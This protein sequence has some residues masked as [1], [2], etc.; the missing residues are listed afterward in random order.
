MR[1]TVRILAV[2]GIVAALVGGADATALAS[3]TPVTAALTKNGS[4]VTA[5]YA[6]YLGRSPSQ[7]DIDY[8]SAKLAAG[9][10]RTVISDSFV[11]SDEYRMIRITEAY[12]H[13]LGRGVD[14]GGATTWLNYMK[15][16]V[17]TTDDIEKNLYQS[18]EFYQIAADN[19]HINPNDGAFVD[20]LYY[21]ILGRNVVGDEGQRWLSSP[22]PEPRSYYVNGI[23]GSLEA[24]RTRVTGMYQR[25]LGRTPDEQGIEVWAN[26]DLA[27]GDSATRKGITS[28]D[29]YL[30]LAANRFH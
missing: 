13:V 27:I 14:P 10:P 23:Y 19:N 8:W 28:S 11:D 5:L 6:D 22:F 17:I 24:A 4:F 3:S 15:A 25:Y 18:N 21:Y 2:A 20:S 12:Q 7:S 1:R 9:A 16:G 26:V 29:E 30:L